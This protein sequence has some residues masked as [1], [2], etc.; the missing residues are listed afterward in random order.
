MLPTGLDP[1]RMDNLERVIDSIYKTMLSQQPTYQNKIALVQQLHMAIQQ[2]N[3]N[4]PDL[5]LTKTLY[6]KYV[7]ALNEQ[8]RNAQMNSALNMNMGGYNSALNTSLVNNNAQAATALNS[9]LAGNLN[10]VNTNDTTGGRLS[11][12]SN[13]PEPAPTTNT[14]LS[15]NTTSTLTHNVPLAKGYEI[16][17]FLFENFELSYGALGMSKAYEIKFKQGVTMQDTLYT[18]VIKNLVDDNNDYGLNSV[19]VTINSLA[20]HAE[21]N[22]VNGTSF[23]GVIE[24]G[25][26]VQKNRPRDFILSILDC[27]GGVTLGNLVSTINAQMEPVKSKLSALISRV[28][29]PYIIIAFR[30][31]QIPIGLDNLVEDYAQLMQFATEQFEKGCAAITLDL[32]YAVKAGDAAIVNLIKNTIDVVNDFKEINEPETTEVVGNLK[33]LNLYEKVKFLYLEPSQMK[34]LHKAN[35]FYEILQDVLVPLPTKIDNVGSNKIFE[36]VMK[37]DANIDRILL[38]DGINSYNIYRFGTEWYLYKA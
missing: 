8:T 15:Q 21:S 4:N 6:D 17:P 23:N 5:T 12:V 33:T 36:E 32:Q 29:I 14:A 22:G 37:T 13:T 1:M 19:E 18:P 26:I 28:Y 20:M 27:Q 16:L 7:E 31:N 9:A 34:N 35:K 3:P 24:H 25:F 30:K 11:A 10:M 38:S 2:N